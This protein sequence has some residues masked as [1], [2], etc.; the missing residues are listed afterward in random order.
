MW[1]LGCETD[2][3]PPAGS[4][5]RA[6]FNDNREALIKLFYSPDAQLSLTKRWKTVSSGVKSATALAELVSDMDAAM[7]GIDGAQFVVDLRLADPY[8]YGAS[9]TPSA[10]AV[11][12]GAAVTNAGMAPVQKMTIVFNGSLTNPKITNSTNSTW[13]KYTGVI[14]GGNSVTLDTDL[15]TAVTNASV[16]VI[17]SITHQGARNW[18]PLKVGSNTLTLTADAGTGT[19]TVTFQPPYI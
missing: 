1:V 5:A 19:A 17:G 12:V 3:S 16:N 10:L 4:T 9:T 8:F 6:K 11:G 13:V 7:L 15:F 14:S 2:G 18:L